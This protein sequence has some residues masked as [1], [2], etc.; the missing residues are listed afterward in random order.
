MD[1][2]GEVRGWLRQHLPALV[3][4]YDVPAAAVAVLA[5]DEVTEHAAGILNTAT[6]VAASTDS[7]FQLA[8]ITKVWTAT[9][10]MQLVDEGMLDLD[11]PVRQYLPGFRVGDEAASA[12]V[13]T[14]Q[15]LS[16]T[17]G[18]DAEPFI[19]GPDGDGAIGWFVDQYLPGV[20]QLF[21]PGEGFSYSNA[22]FTLLGRIVEILRAKPYRQV[23]R[24][25]LIEPLGLAHAAVRPDEAIRFRTSVGH[26]AAGP[27]AGQRPAA[28]WALP[29]TNEPSGAMLAMS[30]GDLLQFAR[31]QLRGGL[32]PDGARLVSVPSIRA[33]R[34]PQV[35]VP[36]LGPVA[37][38]WGLGLHIEQ[39]PHGQ[40]I[41]HDG[42]NLGQ[43]AMLRL[44]PDKQSAFVLFCNG[45]GVSG[46]FHTI[47]GYLLDELTGIHLPPP[48]TPPTEPRPVD[49]ARYLGRYQAAEGT[50][51]VTASGPGEP[52]TELLL[53]SEPG[54]ATADILGATPLRHRLVRHH[55]DTFVTA[56]PGPSSDPHRSFA[57]VGDDGHGR[58]AFV[59]HMRALPRSR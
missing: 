56:D 3:A 27:G 30:A 28:R 44:V 7:V 1:K 12:A 23:I 40:V 50:I 46:L 33:M 31:M 42:K 36:P 43:H 25:H 47:A 5:G 16:H 18:F 34:Q 49:T 52:A 6:G 19:E 13:T 37:V 51:T 20:E 35:E 26:Q 14:R 54:P 53:S 22:G 17:A 15:L 41:G 59:H 24:E 55:D 29:Y 11:R 58:A 2:L 38:Q 48:L 39:H 4:E 8:S 57:F 32:A 21:G 10:V 45:G 9:L